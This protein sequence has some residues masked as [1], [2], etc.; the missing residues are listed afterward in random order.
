MMV[1]IEDFTVEFE[2]ILEYLDEKKEEFIIAD[3]K[4]KDPSG[5]KLLRKKLCLT[6]KFDLDLADLH[7]TYKPEEI[8][9]IFKD[10]QFQGFVNHHSE[11][12]EF[13]RYEVKDYSVI[14]GIDLPVKQLL[15]QT[16]NEF[17]VQDLI[18]FF[19]VEDWYFL[20]AFDSEY[21]PSSVEIS[22]I[23]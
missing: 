12:Y 11:S 14:C 6:A 19:R 3:I 1:E 17:T 16:M 21:A 13:T 2:Q 15:M 8:N 5:E 7:E 20:N 18:D 23:D 9:S 4:A 10:K 22:V